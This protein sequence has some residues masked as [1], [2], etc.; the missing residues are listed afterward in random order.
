MSVSHRRRAE[1]DRENIDEV[2]PGKL[3]P[4]FR[5]LE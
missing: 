1:P 2:S 4:H 5:Q 3:K